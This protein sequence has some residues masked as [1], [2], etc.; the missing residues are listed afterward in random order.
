MDYKKEYEKKLSEAERLHKVAVETNN[1]NTR[2]TLEELYPELIESKDERTRREIIAFIEWAEDRGSMRDDWHQK[3]LPEKWIHWLKNRK[4]EEPKVKIITP[5]FRVGDVVIES[6]RE[7][8]MEPERITSIEKDGYCVDNGFIG[9]AFE[10]DYELYTDTE[11]SKENEEKFKSHSHWKP[12][13]EQ[14]ETIQEI[15][16]LDCPPNFKKRVESLYTDLKKL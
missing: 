1:D 5:K 14:M 16:T 15:L 2:M 6:A 11:W 4:E 10:K 12:S 13:E 7:K 3:K 9:F 8:W